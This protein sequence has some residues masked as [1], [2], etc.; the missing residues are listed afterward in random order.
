MIE[1]PVI[2]FGS[3]LSDAGCAREVNEDCGVCIHPGDGELL[4]AK[5]VLAIVADG[6]GGHSAGE[7]ASRV[8][9]E[10]IGNYYYETNASCKEALTEAF[11]YAN[12]RIYAHA[13]EQAGLN[14]MGTT[15]T[16]IALRA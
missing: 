15:C 14:G 6:M 12:R 4:S 9:I 5:G 13:Q 8:A 11:R 10:A 2:I 1:A 3:V 7:V 16:A